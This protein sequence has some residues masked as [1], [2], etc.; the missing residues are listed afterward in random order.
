MRQ[1]RLWEALHA[2]CQH[3]WAAA[4]LRQPN[5]IASSPQPNPGGTCK[6]EGISIY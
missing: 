4:A 6:G 2:L 5:T 3:H 1:T